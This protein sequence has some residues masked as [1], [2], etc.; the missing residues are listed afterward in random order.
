M[1]I[2]QLA[3]LGLHFFLKF[4]TRC[5][6]ILMQLELVKLVT[7]YKP[8]I[9]GAN[10]SERIDKIIKNL[11][12]SPMPAQVWLQALSQFDLLSLEFPAFQNC[13]H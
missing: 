13:L 12:L 2:T 4:L 7:S 8:L 5:M 9:A 10:V 1:K 3:F 11:L 6:H